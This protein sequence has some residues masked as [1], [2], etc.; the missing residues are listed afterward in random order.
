MLFKEPLG[1]ILSIAVGGRLIGV[2]L[3]PLSS[4]SPK[5]GTILFIFATLPPAQH[6]AHDRPQEIFVKWMDDDRMN[7][8]S[9]SD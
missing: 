9:S 3:P 2:C 8:I 1:G 7:R 5:V 4:E 6:L